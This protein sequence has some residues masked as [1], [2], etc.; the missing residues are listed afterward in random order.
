MSVT[1]CADGANL[2]C[3]KIILADAE[4]YGGD[5]SLMV[6]WA[7]LVLHHEAHRAVG[8][9]SEIVGELICPPERKASRGAR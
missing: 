4:R 2:M 7:H 6:E 5:G 9:V 8:S 1:K 3:A